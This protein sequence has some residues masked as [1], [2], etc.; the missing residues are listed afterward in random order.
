ILLSFTDYLGDHRIFANISSVDSLSNFDITYADLSRRWFW[1]GRIFD[2]REYYLADDFIDQVRGERGALD[3]QVTGGVGAISYPFTFY[4]RAEI[5]LGYLLRKLSYP[6]LRTD[7][8][9]GEALFDLEYFEDNFPVLQGALI[10]DSTTFASFGPV[11]GR[12]WRLSASYAPDLEDSGTLASSASLE[13]RQYIQV[14][15]RSNVAMRFFGGI[16]EG[17]RPNLFFFGGLDTIRGERFRSI[18]GD[19]GF[20]ANLEYRFP[21]IDVIATPVLAFQGI[22]GILFVDAGGAWF[23]DLEEFDFYD[24]DTDRFDDGILAYGWGVTARFLGFDLNWDF[25]KKYKPRLVDGE[26]EEDGFET[27]FWVGTRF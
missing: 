21:L 6:A 22:R 23:N 12:R 18:S 15:Q 16:S 5:G 11:N 3:Y 20:F 13:A 7:P 17:N 10:G 19:R 24:S 25:S 4:Q 14:T 9:T 1:Y 26:E 8:D 2:F 27:V